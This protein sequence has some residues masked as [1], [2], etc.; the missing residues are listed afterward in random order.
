[1]ADNDVEKSNL[2]LM[3]RKAC[4]LMVHA[5]CGGG[6]PGRTCFP[7]ATTRFSVHRS[8]VARLWKKTRAKLT[9]IDADNDED[10]TDYLNNPAAAP[11][12]AFTS[13]ASNRRKGKCKCDRQELKA[14]T[15]D[16]TFSK[17]RKIRHLAAVL[18]MPTT[19]I[20]RMLHQ[21]NYSSAFQ[22]HSSQS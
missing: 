5:L 7:I 16:I 11:D 2:T 12:E 1:M 19:T 18:D 10:N 8:A 20:H 13:Q 22:A 17:R 4:Y 9:S 15:K 6:D 14:T 3:N 21:E